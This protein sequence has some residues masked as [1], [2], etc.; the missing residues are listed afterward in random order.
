MGKKRT[1]HFD[2]SEGKVKMM[3]EI[4]NHYANTAYPIGLSSTSNAVMYDRL[5]SQLQ[6]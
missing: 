1:F 5:I 2:G 6:K 4:L 3:L